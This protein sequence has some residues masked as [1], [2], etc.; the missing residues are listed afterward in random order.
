[1]GL[2]IRDLDATADPNYKQRMMTPRDPTRFRGVDLFVESRCASGHT[3]TTRMIG[4]T[5]EL[6][7]VVVNVIATSMRCACGARLW[8]QVSPR[9][10][11]EDDRRQRTTLPAPPPLPVNVAAELASTATGERPPSEMPIGPDGGPDSFG[12]SDY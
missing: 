1:M 4:H 3:S 7:G 8:H 12:G 10:L 11:A 5:E 2:V 6:A 9:E